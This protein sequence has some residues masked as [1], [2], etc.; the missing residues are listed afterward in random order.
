M[1]RSLRVSMGRPR[2]GGW[3]KVL[4]VVSGFMLLALVWVQRRARGQ[5]SQALGT[6]PAGTPPVREREPAIPT[7]G[8]NPLLERP[9]PYATPGATSGAVAGTAVGTGTAKQPEP[10]TA[11]GTATQ[12]RLA[13]TGPDIAAWVG[14]LTGDTATGAARET[15]TAVPTEDAERAGSETTDDT[16]AETIPTPAAETTAVAAAEGKDWIEVKGVETCPPEFPIK[17]NATSRIYHRPGE[18]SYEATIPE[19]CFANEAAAIAKGYRARKG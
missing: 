3:W 16:A 11:A 9:A 4:L 7:P 17:G 18:P 14:D 5:E 12:E 13:T 2:G 10:V 6:A 19:L 8:V 1:S 15:V